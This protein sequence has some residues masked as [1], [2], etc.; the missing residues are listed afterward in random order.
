MNSFAP[1]QSPEGAGC[2][3]ALA[4]VWGATVSWR[5]GGELA[6]VSEMNGCC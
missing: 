5:V 3:A 6:L 1:L 4:H 2:S